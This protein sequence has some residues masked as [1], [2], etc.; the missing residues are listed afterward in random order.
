MLLVFLSQ[1]RRGDFNFVGRAFGYLAKWR[2]DAGSK[3]RH[4]RSTQPGGE[5]REKERP[6]PSGAS[7]VDGGRAS[8]SVTFCVYVCQKMKWKWNHN[9]QRKRNPRDEPNLPPKSDDSHTIPSP[10]ICALTIDRKRSLSPFS[11]FLTLRLLVCLV[12]CPPRRVSAPRDRGAPLLPLGDYGIL[13][14]PEGNL[15]RLHAMYIVK[16]TTRH[17]V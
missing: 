2:D 16:R 9:L 1:P 3:T 13:S 5:E 6:W 7:F 4:T 10:Y 14:D 12:A 17:A 11:P 8:Y 15:L